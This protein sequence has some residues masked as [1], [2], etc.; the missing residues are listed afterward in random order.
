MILPYK[1]DVND[2]CEI[3]KEEYDRLSATGML[4][5]IFPDAP[6]RWPDHETNPPVSQIQEATS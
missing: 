1:G 5:E 4:F 3:T 2:P 6:I